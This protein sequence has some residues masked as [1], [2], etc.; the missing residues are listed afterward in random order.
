MEKRKQARKLIYALIG[1]SALALNACSV[2]C[3]R[4]YERRYIPFPENS[5]DSAFECPY[6]II[7]SRPADCHRPAL[8][9]PPKKANTRIF[10]KNTRRTK[11]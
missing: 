2:T 5:R 11:R 6:F 9:Q 3:G 8:H 10:S 7:T 4:G 1:A